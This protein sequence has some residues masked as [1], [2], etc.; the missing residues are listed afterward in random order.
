MIA[1]VL[2]TLLAVEPL[3][4]PPAPP[5][6][7]HAA[8]A[9]RAPPSP[10]RARPPAPEA[11]GGRLLGEWPAKP[12][13][14]TVTLDDKMDVDEALGN[15]A[16]AAGWSLVANTGR[17]GDRTLILNLR[18]VPVE[19]AL[20]AVLEGTPLAA[21]RRG[22]TV[23]VAPMRAAPVEV[24][25]LSGFEKPTGKRVTADM[26]DAPV[27]KALRQIADAAGLALV[28]PPGLRGAVTAHFKDTPVEEALRAVLLQTGLSAAREGSIL[29][30]SRES[31]PRI[32]ISGGKRS[33]VFPGVEVEGPTPDEAREIAEEARQAA[34]E[35]R[36][37]AGEAARDAQ[38]GPGTAGRRGRGR[39][40]IK[41][42]DVTVAPGERLRDVVAI[43]GSVR[44]GPG[45]SARQITALLGSVD[46]EPGATVDREVVAIGGNVHVYPGA[47]VGKDAVS[48]GG[49][50]VIDPGGVVEGE[51]TAIGIPGL[52]GVLSLLGTKGPEV[53]RAS[54]LLKVGHLLAKYVVFLALGLLV[55]VFAPR[56]LDSVAGAIGASP[57]KVL[58]VGLLGTLALPVLA[59]L[60]VATVIGIPLVA[61]QVLAVLLAGVLGFT[62]LALLIG[63]RLPLALDR[64]AAVIQL[65]IGTAIVVAVTQIPVLGA[66][67]YVA[68]WLFVFGAVLRTRF[69]QPPSEAALPTT[70]V[71][72][73]PPP[74]GA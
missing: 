31:G 12:S 1:L 22:D 37:A 3:P 49:D 25:V 4:A 2:A 17:D 40:R 33:V 65:A 35:A 42:G 32:V 59:V 8:T 39:D 41:G 10:V 67:A 30:V 28:L 60:L 19:Q 29:T 56:R 20:R 9:P 43:H 61:V 26:T 50:V 64:G 62:A 57:M 45:A 38:E 13:G 14:R 34:D 48:V 70:A 71:P 55:L 58:L 15:I 53:R 36:Q 73:P 54:P 51:Q 69:G 7:P 66:L 47:R 27:D 11:S 72:P 24:P 5:A 46:V 16:E 52:G 18:G 74:A 21:T 44:V 68:A 23:T 63:R 6:L